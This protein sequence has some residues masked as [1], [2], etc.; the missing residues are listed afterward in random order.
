[1]NKALLTFFIISCSLTIL[2]NCSR[3]AE[4]ELPRKVGR[5]RAAFPSYYFNSL[6]NKCELFMYGGCEGKKK[7]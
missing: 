7:K 5:C 2:V 6:L 1:M 4:C 3:P